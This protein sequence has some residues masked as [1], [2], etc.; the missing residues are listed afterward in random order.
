VMDLESLYKD[1]LSLRNIR[2]WVFDEVFKSYLTL[3]EVESTDWDDVLFILEEHFQDVDEI[4]V[5][6]ILD[7]I[8][9]RIQ[10]SDT[11]LRLI[12]NLLEKRQY[13]KILAVLSCELFAKTGYMLFQTL[14][15]FVVVR[16]Y[17]DLLTEVNAHAQR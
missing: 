16:D 9:S 11:L 3:T 6:K 7:T 17:K 2:Y 12:N 8:K 5:T 1:Y 13:K 10:L 15:G 4:T 14:S